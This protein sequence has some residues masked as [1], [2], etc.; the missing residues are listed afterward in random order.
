VAARFRR[1]RGG[2][3]SVSFAEGEAEL[4]RA[5]L[6]DL[7]TLLGSLDDGTTDPGASPA[8]DAATD[9]LVAMVG[10]G[11]A[12]AAPEDPALARL[13]PDGYTDDDAA[14]A[15]FRRYTQVGLRDARRAKIATALA[16]LDA[17]THGRTVLDAE[18]AQ[19]WL[20]VLNDL[21]LVLGE[22]LEVTEDLEGMLAAMAPGDPRRAALGIYDWLGW[23]QET[24][25][26]ALLRG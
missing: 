6:T 15:D 19:A 20:G 23:V 7:F 8:A 12:T 22:R 21:R 24:L 13:F 9:P 26:R 17:S 25:V 4:L 14:S 18:T 2:R 11:T 10:I 1:A 5:M 16:T 3:V